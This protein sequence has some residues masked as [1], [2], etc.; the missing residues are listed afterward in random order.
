M[1]PHLKIFG[2]RLH[3]IGQTSETMAQ[4]TTTWTN[5]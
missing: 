2:E 1:E 3:S 5:T 4:H